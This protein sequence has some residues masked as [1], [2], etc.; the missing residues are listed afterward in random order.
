[1]MEDMLVGGMVGLLTA[2]SIYVWRSK[3]F[4]KTQKTL[5]L[6]CIIFA[7]LQWL[8]IIAFSIYNK[9]QFKNSPERISEKKSRET[10]IKLD[11]TIESLKN[12]KQKGILTE[13]EYMLKLEKIK[14]E[15]ANEELKKST[16]YIQLKNLLDSGILTKEE[17]ENKINEISIIYKGKYKTDSNKKTENTNINDLL[18]DL[19]KNISELTPNTEPEPTLTETE[20]IHLISKVEGLSGMTVNE[21]IYNCGLI[22]EFDKAL[23]YDKKKAKKILFLLGVDKNTIKKFVR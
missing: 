22:E 12:L 10:K 21:R 15:K 2:T 17:F 7:P 18:N 3:S 14:L 23:I 19:E 6:I 9:I 16:V 4:S 5:L 11:T 8:G 20:I 1:M 13:Q